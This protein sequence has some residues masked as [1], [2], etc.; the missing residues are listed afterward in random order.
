MRRP[1]VFDG[2]GSLAGSQ[3]V[4]DGAEILEESAQSEQ[5]VGCKTDTP[6]YA[7][8]L[9]ARQST[10]IFATRNAFFRYRARSCFFQAPIFEFAAAVPT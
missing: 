2:E 9:C 10:R 7:G 3:T 6:N 5:V 1:V 8:A 4:G